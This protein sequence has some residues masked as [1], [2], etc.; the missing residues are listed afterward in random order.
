LLERAELTL[1][2]INV[3][4]ED[5]RR[6]TERVDKPTGAVLRQIEPDTLFFTPYTANLSDITPIT[7]SNTLHSI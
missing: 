7:S 4:L 6:N 1:I 5:N 2:A 3:L